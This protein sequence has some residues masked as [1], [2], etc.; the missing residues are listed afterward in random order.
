[1]RSLPKFPLLADLLEYL[2]TT[3]NSP[4]LFEEKYSMMEEIAVE[5]IEELH[6]QGLTE[7]VCTDLEK[8]AYSVNDGISDGQLRN[9][10]VLAGI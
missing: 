10:N 2:I 5:I 7:A 4:A 3:D 9:M 6:E 1:M 8:H